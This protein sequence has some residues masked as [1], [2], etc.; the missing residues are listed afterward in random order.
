MLT[1]FNFGLHVGPKGRRFALRQ[2]HAES[3]KWLFGMAA[4]GRHP[5]RSNEKSSEEFEVGKYFVERSFKSDE[6]LRDFSGEVRWLQAADAGHR[7]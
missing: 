1:V 3:Q 6:I 2:G 7:G 4:L 5:L